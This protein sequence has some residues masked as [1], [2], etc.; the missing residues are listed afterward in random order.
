MFVSLQPYIDGCLRR[1][2]FEETS[3]GEAGVSRRCMVFPA[4]CLARLR[5]LVVRAPELSVNTARC[6]EYRVILEA[7]PCRRYDGVTEGRMQRGAN[8]RDGSPDS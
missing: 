3:L 5:A 7:I 2:T 8:V 1:A 6:M 4:Q